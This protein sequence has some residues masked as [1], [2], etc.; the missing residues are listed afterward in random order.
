MKNQD[1]HIGIVGAGNIGSTIY[2][3]LVSG[4]MSYKV[5]I[6]DQTEKKDIFIAD[7]N[8]VKLE[9]GSTQFNQFVNGKTLIV[10]A[11]PYHQNIN[12][13]KACQSAGVAYFDLSEDDGLD[14]YIA[15]SHQGIPFTMPHCGLAPGM[16]T[17]VANHLLKG[18]E[19]PT[20]VKIRVGAL[21]QNASNKLRY[22]TSWSGEGLVNEYIGDCQ[23]LQNGKY[24]TVDALTGYEKVTLDGE[25][26]EA[27]NTSGGLGTFAKTLDGKYNSLD[28]N[29]KTLRRIGHHNYVDFLFNDLKIPQNELTDIFRRIPKT[30][31]DIVILYASASGEGMEDQI[32]YFK[33]FKPKDINGRF[34]TAIEYTTAIGLLSM[35]EL[36]IKGKIPQEGYVRQEDV[37]W[38]DA[39]S[40]T[41]GSIYKG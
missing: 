28:L 33:I 10:N 26:Y 40:T 16:S 4:G 11:L 22:Y 30:N 9:K 8:Y 24:D 6:A 35:V 39:T 18:I 23:V 38:K 31:K 12:L 1:I 20:S 25:E 7:D 15:S 3:L 13:Y 41:F 34:L 19:N 29:Y 17:V 5:S 32:T 14:E 37:N 21:S 2:Q 36:Y 27:F